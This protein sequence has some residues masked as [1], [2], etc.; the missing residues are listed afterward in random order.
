MPKAL[1]IRDPAYAFKGEREYAVR[2]MYGK[3]II[4]TDKNEQKK[5]PFKFMILCV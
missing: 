3:A 1:R 2:L 5:T 4:Q